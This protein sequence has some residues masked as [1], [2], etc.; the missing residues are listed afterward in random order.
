[1]T[2]TVDDIAEE[3]SF[4]TF[5]DD[6][7]LLGNLLNDILLH[8]AGPKFTEK[9]ERIKLLAQVRVFASCLQFCCCYCACLGMCVSNWRET[10]V[11]VDGVV[12]CRV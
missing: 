6:C 10:R 3:I 8:E 1:M 12:W 2:D 5:D 11:C 9:V 7:H 4:Q